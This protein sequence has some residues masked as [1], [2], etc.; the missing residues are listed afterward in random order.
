[1]WTRS[2]VEP[3]V[4]VRVGGASTSR[5]AATG[6]QE[7]SGLSGSRSVRGCNPESSFQESAVL[8]PLRYFRNTCTLHDVTTFLFSTTV[9][10]HQHQLFELFELHRNR[11][12]VFGVFPAGEIVDL[13]HLRVILSNA[14]DAL[15]VFLLCFQPSS[16]S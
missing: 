2:P 5:V 4:G 3:V 11:H 14:D 15:M 12:Q 9:H 10:N 7:Q 8:G 1:M 6:E 13:S 16:S